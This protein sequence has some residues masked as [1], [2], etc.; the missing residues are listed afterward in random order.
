M[1]EPYKTNYEPDIIHIT[2]LF[3]L[4]ISYSIGSLF[5]DTYSLAVSAILHCFVLD[6]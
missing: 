5:M 4:I 2:V 6:E 1:V 3:F